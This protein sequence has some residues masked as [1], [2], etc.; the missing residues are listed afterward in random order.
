MPCRAGCTVAFHGPKVG[1][2]VAPGR[3]HAGAVVVADIGIPLAAWRRRRR[4]VAG[5]PRRCSSWRRAR[6]RGLDQVHGRRRAGDRRGA[7]A[8]P[9]R[10]CS[11]ALAA[12]RVRRGLAWLAVPATCR[13]LGGAPRADGAGAAGRARAGRR[14]D[15]VV[16]GPGLGRADEAGDL[17]PQAGATAPRPDGDRRGRRCSRCPASSSCCARRRMPA[18]LTP[19][20]GE[21]GRLLER[22]SDW[23]RANRVEAVRSAAAR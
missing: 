1:L 19:H 2:V 14:A 10:R 7:R 15:A 3:D 17:A 9:A 21:L 22:D 23:V 12:L 13:V 16:L 11:P 5:D 6:R 4:V 8:C 20:E 18:V